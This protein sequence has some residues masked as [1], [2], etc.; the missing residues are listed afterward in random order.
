MLRHRNEVSLNRNKG[1][2]GLSNQIQQRCVWYLLMLI[3]VQNMLNIQLL[4]TL[5]RWGLYWT[6]GS[7]KSCA[8]KYHWCTG[9]AVD[10]ALMDW[11]HVQP[12]YLIYQHCLGIALRYGWQ[13]LLK[14]WPADN[15]LNDKECWLETYYLCEE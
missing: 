9:T 5:K 7:D 8:K 15:G 4:D 10:V 1:K 6:T 3:Y 11:R 13:V 14:F 12:N 2:T